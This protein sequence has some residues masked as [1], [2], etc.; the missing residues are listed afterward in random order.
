MQIASFPMEGI[1]LQWHRW[2][3]RFHGPL[4]W[5]EFTKVVLHHFGPTDY[6]DPSKALTWLKQTFIVEA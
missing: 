1:A 2:L 3:S 5:N 4:N 6:E